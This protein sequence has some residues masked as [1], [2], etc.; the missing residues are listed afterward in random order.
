MKFDVSRD[1]L[2]GIMLQHPVQADRNKEIKANGGLHFLPSSPDGT[3][4]TGVVSFALLMDGSEAPFAKA[5][6]RFLF[7][8]DEKWDPKAEQ[9]HPFLGQLLVHGASKIIAVMNSLCLHANMPLVP[10]SAESLVSQL[11]GPTGDAPAA[12]G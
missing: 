1:F 10:I 9:S 11:R 3:M 6:W 7:T 2:D 5:G 8:S 12:E 4:H